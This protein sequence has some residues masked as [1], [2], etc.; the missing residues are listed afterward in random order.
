MRQLCGKGSYTS[1]PLGDFGKDFM[2]E[3]LVRGCTNILVDE[4]DVGLYI[5]KAANIKAL[6]TGDIVQVNR[7]FKTPISLRFR[8]FMVQCLNSM[9]RIKD[10]SDSFL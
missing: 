2:L 6:I 8:G 1:I 4:N 3:P 10:K 7:K 9:P 5:D